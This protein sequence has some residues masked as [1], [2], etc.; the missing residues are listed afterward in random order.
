MQQPSGDCENE[1]HLLKIE[2]RKINR[3]GPLMTSG[4]AL[5]VQDH[6]SLDLLL[7]VTNVVKKL[8]T[9][10][11]PI[12]LM[13]RYLQLNAMLVDTLRAFKV[14]WLSSV[15]LPFILVTGVHICLG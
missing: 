8:L 1:S 2:R 7:H 9:C 4:I 10:L 6:L 14:C 3:T 5:L 11:S 13:F 15:L 12:S